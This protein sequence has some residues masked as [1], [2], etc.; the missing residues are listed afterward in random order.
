MMKI[1]IKAHDES[2]KDQI[3]KREPPFSFGMLRNPQTLD[4]LR[5]LYYKKLRAFLSPLR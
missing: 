5:L 1:F 2:P 3:D 4:P